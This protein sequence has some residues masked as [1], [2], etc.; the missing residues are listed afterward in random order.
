MLNNTYL[1]PPFFILS[2]VTELVTAD[3]HPVRT[4]VCIMS[5]WLAMTEYSVGPYGTTCK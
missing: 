1:F 5:S 2:V 3:Y 4:C